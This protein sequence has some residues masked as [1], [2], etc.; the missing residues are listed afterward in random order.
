MLPADNLLGPIEQAF[1][2]LRES[3][4]PGAW[5]PTETQTGK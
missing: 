3:A 2:G 1:H 4:N 5:Q